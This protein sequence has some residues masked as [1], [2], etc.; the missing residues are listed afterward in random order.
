MRPYS[1]MTEFE[2]LLGDPHEPAAPLSFRSALATDESEC[3]PAEA[4]SAAHRLGLSPFPEGVTWRFEDVLAKARAMSRR[5]LT[6]AVALGQTLLGA[7]PVLLEGDAAMRAAL[8]RHNRSG[9]LGCL[10]LTERDHGGDLAAIEMRARPSADGYMLSGE[11]WLIN[12]A[13]RGGT[14]TLLVDSSP[15]ERSELSLLYLDKAG[16]NASNY[17]HLDKIRTHGIRGADIAGINFTECLAPPSALIGRAGSGFEITLKTLQISRI[18]CS[19]FSVGALDTAL[20]T[21]ATFAIS[22]RL[23]RSG[24]LEIPVVKSQLAGAFVD[25]LI[26]QVVARMCHRAIHSHQRGLS[27]V[28]AIAKY[29]VPHRVDVAIRDCARILGARHYVRDGEMHGIFQKCMRDH[30]VVSLFDGSS[31]VNLNVIASH[32]PSLAY[33]RREVRSQ[34]GADELRTLLEFQSE[35][36]V[37]AFPCSRDLSMVSERDPIVDNLPALHEIV[38]RPGVRRRFEAMPVMVRRLQGLATEL[39]AAILS[40]RAMEDFNPRSSRMFALAERYC[41]IYAATA[42]VSAWAFAS[43][44]CGLLWETEW[45]VVALHRLGVIPSPPESS[46]DERLLGVLLDLV[47]RGELL[48]FDADG[49]SAARL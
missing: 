25:G 38:A 11:K 43:E 7:I 45:L 4:V 36:S 12:N 14:V 44:D 41:A 23:F 37:S 33:A 26:C 19:G 39:D 40:A 34:H 3:F 46:S 8:A 35:M 47:H 2:A 24:M 28:S 10:A 29:F 20:R 1:S 9:V 32:L 42:C 5:D 17:R 49:A 31:S 18:L 21:A 48:A 13:S 16:L 22:R 15:S 30:E 6:I 27:L